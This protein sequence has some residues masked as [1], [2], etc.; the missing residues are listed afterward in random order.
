MDDRDGVQR[1]GAQGESAVT[2]E[3]KV[4]GSKSMTQRALIIAALAD[5]PIS[6]DR[7]LYCDD[8][9]H[10]TGMLENLGTGV[11]WQGDSVYVTPGPLIAGGRAMFCGNAGTAMRFG[12]CLSLVSGGG[13]TMD[14]DARMRERPIG[15]LGD[16]LERLGVSVK[17]LQKRGYPPMSLEVRGI[18][19]N[20]VTVDGSVS[21]QF[22][23]GLLMA[24][25]RLDRGLKVTLEGEIVSSP[26]IRMTISMMKAA[27]AKVRWQNGPDIEVEPGGYSAASCNGRI[28]V[29]A[30]WSAAAFI[31]AASFISGK[32]LGVPGLAEPG[33]SLQG[34]AAFHD[35]LTDLRE[36]HLHR[37][38]LEDT[39]D[40][41][42]PLAAAALFSSDPVEIEGAEHT[43]VKESDRIAI[44]CRELRKLGAEI[45]ER[46]D[47]MKVFPL[48]E[49]P[50]G[51]FRMVPEND[52]RMA[53]AFGIVS[54]MVPGIEVLQKDCVTK[55]F[56][57]F[58]EVLGAV[59][60][61]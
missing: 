53:M 24:G 16:A 8:S 38:N 51:N 17:Y 34:D 2:I 42:A 13:M 27:G 10:L 11:S 61:A 23:S 37:F 12:S 55:S 45:E 44:L 57:G 30:D 22:A 33:L 15:P 56:P 40:L 21:S 47:G 6:I 20:E 50:A 28:E 60:D 46:R 31:M 54:L 48:R 43:R 39:P 35:F 7:A 26:Y 41:I 32:P 59:R 4:P 18:P 9:H 19:G 52:H 14:G 36:P 1:R 49:V 3:I 29:E 25:A 5:S 58:W